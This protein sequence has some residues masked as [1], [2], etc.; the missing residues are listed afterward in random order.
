MDFF[1]FFGAAGM[2]QY[3]ATDVHSSTRLLSY[4][5]ACWFSRQHGGYAAEPADPS[6]VPDSVIEQNLNLM[7]WH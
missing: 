2:Q 5:P 6:S 4:G 1:F 3:E 7:L